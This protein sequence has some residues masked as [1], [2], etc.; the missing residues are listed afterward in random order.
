MIIGGSGQIGLAAAP[1]LVAAGWRVIAVQR[2]RFES[3]PEGVETI[4]IDRD[5][6]VALARVVGGGVDAIIDTIA[7]DEG[8]ARQ[9]LALRGRVGAFVVISSA[10]VYRDA[11]G[12]TLD[13]AAGNGFP[14]FPEPIGED[15]PTVA[16]GPA[17]YSTR[18]AALERVL[19]DQDDAP[20]TILR[21]CAIHGVGSRWPREWF[22]VKRIL[23]GR[24]AVP[25]AWDGQSR[26]HTTA[27][28]NIAALIE[29]VLD[30]PGVRA[31]NI[32]DPVAP[33]VREIGEA[34]A[35]IYGHDWRLIPFKG[36]PRDGVGDNPWA[37]PCPLVVDLARAEALGWRPVAHYADVVAPACRSIEESARRGL[38]FAPYL[39]TMFDYDAEDQWLAARG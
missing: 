27:T 19:L 36:A 20:V 14:R 34:I 4:L 9:L 2:A 3:T 15:Q 13:E 31:L 22:F 24:R 28:V 37:V 38:P 11:E 35:R 29:V 6:P 5:E 17:T 26:F 12:R 32:A 21:P 16:P 18:K 10:S 23:D 8:H 7:Y 33:S 30:N 39:S 1:R 25:L